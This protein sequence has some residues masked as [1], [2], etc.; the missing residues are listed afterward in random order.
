MNMTDEKEEV[1]FGGERGP[2]GGVSFWII[3][4]NTCSACKIE[5]PTPSRQ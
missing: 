3:A 5:K 2:G 4:G 1:V